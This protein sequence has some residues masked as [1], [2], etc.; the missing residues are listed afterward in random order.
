[1]CMKRFASLAK[2]DR[3][4][5]KSTLL[6]NSRLFVAPGICRM[7]RKLWRLP[8]RGQCGKKR[9]YKCGHTSTRAKLDHK[10]AK[11]SKLSN[12]SGFQHRLVTARA[13]KSFA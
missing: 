8:R 3:I 4:G 10:C 12:L 5:K 1:M 6:R 9:K 7:R 13:N 11:K 2:V